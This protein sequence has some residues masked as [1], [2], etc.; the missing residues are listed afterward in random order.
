ML[1]HSSRLPNLSASK[2][3]S[4]RFNWPTRVIKGASTAH[5]TETFRL[6]RGGT[7]R[8]Y[9]DIQETFAGADAVADAATRVAD[10]DSAELEALYREAT[11]TWQT[12]DG[13]SL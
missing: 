3:E 6:L 12:A 9:A 4:P 7:P 10:A 2:G 11:Q 5:G 13:D 1:L 8:V